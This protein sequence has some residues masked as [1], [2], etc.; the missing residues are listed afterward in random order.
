MLKAKAKKRSVSQSV[1]SRTQTGNE[2]GD[3]LPTDN[4][5]VH[6]YR[7]LNEDQM[8]TIVSNEVNLLDIDVETQFAKMDQIFK[9]KW[10]QDE[11]S[12]NSHRHA[13]TRCF[14]YTKQE[15]FSEGLSRWIVPSV[16]HYD[17]Y[18]YAYTMK[19]NSWKC[20]RYNVSVHSDRW[21]GVGREKRKKKRVLFPREICI[22]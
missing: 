7:F 14:K 1:M 21:P 16:G 4:V 2:Q 18:N 6:W 8:V 3:W 11:I 10:N 20:V 15:I 5:V 17:N 19:F 12:S 13:Q 22:M 9:L